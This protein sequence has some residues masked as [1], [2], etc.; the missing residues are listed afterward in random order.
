MHVAVLTSNLTLT[1]KLLKKG[2]IANLQDNDGETSLHMAET[3]SMTE[4]LLKNGNA[5][6]SIPNIDG[7]TALHLAVQARNVDSVRHLL[8]H[9]A[10]MNSADNVKWFTPLHLIALPSRDSRDE[11]SEAETR[12]RIAELLAGGL[13]NKW[14]PDLDFGDSDGNTPL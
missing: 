9:N 12:P 14:E 4:T 11:V 13:S 1:Q 3:A 10:N 5:N 8:L 7:I 6:P 2:A